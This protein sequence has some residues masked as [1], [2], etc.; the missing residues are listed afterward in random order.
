M[1]KL[2]CLLLES[3]VEDIV[4]NFEKSILTKY[5]QLDSFEIYYDGNNNSIFFSDINIK[6]KFRKKGIGSKVL[7]DV[8]NFGDKLKLPI[9][10]IPDS[11]DIPRLIN[12]YKRFGF[13]VNSGI[14]KTL[15]IP[16]AI[17]MFRLPI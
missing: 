3:G 2:K 1:I 13:V 10:L 7:T 11:D 14:N 17:S 4:S 16:N 9:V 15:N 12:F 5:P 8:I 6:K